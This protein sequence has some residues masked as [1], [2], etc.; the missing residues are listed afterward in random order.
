M[1]VTIALALIA[2]LHS[3]AHV[4]AGHHHGWRNRHNP[5]HVTSCT[6]VVLNRLGSQ[7]VCVPNS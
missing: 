2:A 4:P 5:H 1:N 3:P 7:P 6:W